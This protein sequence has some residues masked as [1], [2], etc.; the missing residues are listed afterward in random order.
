MELSTAPSDGAPG[1]PGPPPSSNYGE[2]LIKK[3]NP[4]AGAAV[5]TLGLFIAFGVL[6][7]VPSSAQPVA[8]PPGNAEPA[9]VQAAV[10]RDPLGR[11]TPEGLVHGLLKAMADEDYAR[12]ARYLDLS[13]IPQY[14]RD[15]RGQELARALQQVLDEGG[16]VAANWQLSSN[17]AGQQNDGLPPEQEQF[18]T[19]RTPQGTVGLIAERLEDPQIG[20][21]WRVSS[22]TV[23]QLPLL[24]ERIGAGLIDRL[25][26]KPLTGGPRFGGV[27]LGHWAA[28]LVLSITAYLTAWVFTSMVVFVIHRL[29]GWTR[30]ERAVRILGAAV[31]P[32]R[33]YLAVWVFAIGSIYLGVSVIARQQFGY[34]AEIVAWVAL[35]WFL[36]RIIDTL[37]E[38]GSQRMSQRSQFGALS[39]IRFFRR[40][41]QFVIA[42]VAGIA[43]L[44]TLGVDVTAGLAA[45][46]IGGIAVALGAQKTVDN[47][48]GSLTLIADRPVRIGDFC[49]FGETSGTVEDIGMRSTRIRTLDR[50]VITVPN[51]QLS[52]LPIENYSRRDR[53]WFHPALALRYET[54]PDQIRYLLVELRALLYAHPRVDPDPARVRFLGLGAD[55]LNIEIFA[56]VHAG[57]H[58]DFLEVQEDL[59]LRIMDIVAESGASFAFSSR[60]LYMAKDPAPADDKR[61]AAAARVHEWN[62]NKELQLPRFEANRIAALRGSLAYPPEGSAGSSTPVVDVT[63]RPRPDK[64]R[65]GEPAR[66]VWHWHGR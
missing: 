55:C 32:F 49:R 41:G 46:G 6:G 56:Y 2:V 58:S 33:I 26:P 35:G 45:L 9:S 52:A 57:D 13:A 50:T 59:T 62:E 36:W 54:T 34:L 43:A 39:A 28:L 60:T 31:L 10:P 11:E 3:R 21:I 44:N 1:P 23:G 20:K 42:A 30:G 8:A 14:R 66:K 15:S 63:D 4:V 53:F 37:G 18:A 24:L 51:G 16:W 12:A 29:W 25:L 64:A 27:P 38:I 5:A 47:L 22:D 40:A 17:P 48:V 65:K 7:P 61:A 19:V